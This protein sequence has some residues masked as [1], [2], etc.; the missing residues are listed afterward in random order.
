MAKIKAVLDQETWVEVDVP[1]EFQAIVISFLGSDPL[2]GGSPDGS[3]DNVYD[4][5]LVSAND[6]STGDYGEGNT[7][8]NGEKMT[9]KK[10]SAENTT[11]EKSRPLSEAIENTKADA[12][13]SSN[14]NVKDRKPTSHT[15]QYRGSSYHMVNW[16]VPFLLISTFCYLYPFPTVAQFFISLWANH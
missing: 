9:T 14:N 6:G 15:L 13:T 8:Q 12:V 1:D 11:H 2:N 16:L 3:R 4:G 10:S 7:H 5:D